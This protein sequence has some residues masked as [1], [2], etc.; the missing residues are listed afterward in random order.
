M[1]APIRT[2][3][4]FATIAATLPAVAQDAN[5]PSYGETFN[6]VREPNGD[7]VEVPIPQSPDAIRARELKASIALSL[8]LVKKPDGDWLEIYC[9]NLTTN[10]IRLSPNDLER[11]L[12]FGWEVD[13]K[14]AVLSLPAVK[15]ISEAPPMKVEI[16]PGAAFRWGQVTLS[17]LGLVVVRNGSTRGPRPMA[18]ANPS[19]I[20][21]IVIKP[22]AFWDMIIARPGRMITGS[23]TAL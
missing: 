16:T 10:T 18:I 19:A 8:T 11:H 9:Q 22:T 20:H 6:L 13:G 3:I 23:A 17:G 1:K 15:A 2:L 7:L 4:V 21:T 12:W 14:R 5:A